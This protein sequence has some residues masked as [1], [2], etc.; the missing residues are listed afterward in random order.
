MALEALQVYTL[1][2]VGDRTMMDTLI[3]F[4]ETLN[5]KQ[6]VAAAIEAAQKGAEATRHMHANMGRASYVPDEDVKKASLPDAG[7]YGLAALLTGLGKA[8]N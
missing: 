1:A 5:T 4:V 2:R 3:P 6:D 7:A 8:L